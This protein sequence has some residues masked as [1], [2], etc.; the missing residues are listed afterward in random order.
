MY[1]RGFAFH[2]FE[3]FH[4]FERLS[5]LFLHHHAD[6]NVQD[7]QGN[8]LFIYAVVRLREFTVL[9]EYVRLREYVSLRACRDED[10]LG[11]QTLRHF[12]SHGVDVNSR[13]GQGR[14]PLDIVC[15]DEFIV[16]SGDVNDAHPIRFVQDGGMNAGDFNMARLLLERGAKV[17]SSGGSSSGSVPPKSSLWTLC[18]RRWHTEHSAVL[19]HLLLLHDADPNERDDSGKTLLNLLLPRQLLN[20]WYT[21]SAS[22]NSIVAMMKVSVD[23]VEHGARVTG[24]YGGDA[25]NAL[26]FRFDDDHQRWLPTGLDPEEPYSLKRVLEHDDPK[27][28]TARSRISIGSSCRR[29][30]WPSSH[31]PSNHSSQP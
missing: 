28:C 23:L 2:E 11:K 8:S 30:G 9:R 14:S 22:W 5:Y 15:G 20:F 19:A 1:C 18:N 7:G 17:S 24:K 13:D 27:L 26:E 6:P 31:L 25:V 4:K 10:D 21:S 16:I 3:A 12:I 29:S